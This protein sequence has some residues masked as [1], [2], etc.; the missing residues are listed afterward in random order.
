MET[1]N[2]NLIETE[3]TE[4]N[5]ST[6]AEQTEGTVDERKKAINLPDL[7]YAKEYLDGIVGAV[8]GGLTAEIDGVSDKCDELSTNV[9][10]INETLATLSESIENAY[11]SISALNDALN[12]L[13]TQINGTWIDATKDGVSINDLTPGATYQI[14]CYSNV[15]GS[16]LCQG[17]YY[18][19]LESTDYVKTILGSYIFKPF[20]SY[21]EHV[22]THVKYRQYVVGIK[23]GYLKAYTDTKGIM[24]ATFDSSGGW[25]YA[26]DFTPSSIE[27]LSFK[28]RRIH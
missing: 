19:S 20:T 6:E 27:Y 2:N 9:S 22:E 25:T 13:Q 26:A 11:E 1:E 18:H 10:N 21:D 23:E 16:G 8:R 28:Y 4:G 14:I 24:S 12:D 17:I 3:E 5:T 15:N 7:R